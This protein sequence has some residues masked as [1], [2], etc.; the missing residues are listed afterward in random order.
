MI[1]KSLFTLPKQLV[2]LWRNEFTRVICDRLTSEQVKMS[3]F[4]FFSLLIFIQTRNDNNQATLTTKTKKKKK[5]SEWI[6]KIKWKTKDE[7]ASKIR[8]VLAFYIIFKFNLFVLIFTRRGLLFFHSCLHRRDR[9]TLECKAKQVKCMCK[10]DVFRD[11]DG[12]V[13]ICC[14]FHTIN[15]H[16]RLFAQID[17]I[18]HY[19]HLIF[20]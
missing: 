9:Y 5:N 4:L 14:H 2:R 1:H 16:A 15:T 17:F 18:V 6:E 8:S 3:F 10:D 11:F 20:I 12:G 19:M 7:A 13:V